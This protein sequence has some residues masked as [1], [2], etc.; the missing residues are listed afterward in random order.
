MYI[1]CICITFEQ[2]EVI[3]SDD[4]E[5]GEGGRIEAADTDKE[6]KGRDKGP[7][8]DAEEKKD[9]D[10]EKKEDVD[11]RE[12]D[13]DNV[14]PAAA[15]TGCAAGGHNIDDDVRSDSNATSKSG[16]VCAHPPNRIPVGEETTLATSARNSTRGAAYEDEED[17]ED[18]R[19]GGR[20]EEDKEDKEDEEEDEEDS[21]ASSGRRRRNNNVSHF[22]NNPRPASALSPNHSL[23]LCLS[24]ASFFCR[25][26]HDVSNDSRS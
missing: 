26:M 14:A 11:V 21:G 5:A 24:Y 18:D 2:E 9:E 15:A 1:H 17:E 25:D 13:G 23:L 8:A 12:R 19:R 7:E 6:E 16:D 20:G 10:G 4:D 22:I 3:V